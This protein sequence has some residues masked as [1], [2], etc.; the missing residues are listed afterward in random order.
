LLGPNGAGKTT[1]LR[2]LTTLALPDSGRARVAGYDV[3]RDPAAAPPHPPVAAPT[4]KLGETPTRRPNPLMLAH[5]TRKPRTAR[6]ARAPGGGG[7]GARPRALELR[8]AGGRGRRGRAGGM[9]GGPGRGPSMRTRPPVLFLDEPTTGLDPKSR[10][11][12]WSV[13]RALVHEGVTVL[14]T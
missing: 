4:A 5:P 2:I 7:G 14:L 13:I 6:P 11:G 8:G 1:A 12:V 3:V 10:Y 9:R